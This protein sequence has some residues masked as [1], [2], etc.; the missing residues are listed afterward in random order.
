MFFAIRLLFSET[1]LF[2]TW[3]IGFTEFLVN[4]TA[5]SRNIFQFMSVS[6]VQTFD[7]KDERLVFQKMAKSFDDWNIIFFN[8][9]YLGLFAKVL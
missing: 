2:V 6:L 7:S 8:G 1:E 9:E 5:S 3:I 4:M